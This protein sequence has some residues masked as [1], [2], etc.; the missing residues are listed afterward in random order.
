MSSSMVPEDD[1]KS[2]VSRHLAGQDVLPPEL[3]EEANFLQV[4]ALLCGGKHVDLEVL[5]F[6]EAILVGVRV[7]DSVAILP[8]FWTR[9]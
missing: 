4:Q 5:S 6:I 7:R 3:R 1:L 2:V 8:R 9:F